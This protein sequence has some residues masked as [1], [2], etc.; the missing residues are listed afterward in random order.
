MTRLG[1]NV[2]HIAT[3]REARKAIEPD[4]VTAALMAELAGAHG[5]TVHLRMDRRHIQERDVRLMRQLVTTRLNVEMA[6]S[7]EN[8]FLAADLKPDTVTLVPE[9]ADEITTEGGLDLVRT[10]DPVRDAVNRLHALDIQVS[11]FIDPEIEQIERAGASGASLI[12]LNTGAYSEAAPKALDEA[13]PLFL[14]EL[15]KI[16]DAAEHARKLDLRVLAGHGLTYRNVGPVSSIP[17]VEELNIGHNIVARAALI[18]M[19]QAVE[20]MLYAMN[21]ST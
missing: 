10:L 21:G 16:V 8:L 4:P 13:D 6:V 9:R 7:E 5:V 20:E 3:I 19:G 18:G 2:D 15:G 11:L 12:E 17:E 1:I 14:E